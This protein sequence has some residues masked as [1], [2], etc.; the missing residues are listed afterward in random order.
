MNKEQISRREFIKGASALTGAAFISCLPLKSAGEK[1][2]RT[3]VDQVTLG[4]TALLLDPSTPSSSRFGFL[5]D[6]LAKAWM[7]LELFTD[8]EEAIAWLKSV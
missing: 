8:E 6:V 2:K 7:H 3:A 1:I 5:K 4:K